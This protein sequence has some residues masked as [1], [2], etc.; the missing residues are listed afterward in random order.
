[1]QALDVAGRARAELGRWLR[2]HASRAR[3]VGSARR[4]L[5]DDAIFVKDGKYYASAGITAGI[6]LCLAFVEEDLGQE[7]ALQ[8]AREMVVYLKRSGGQLQYA[9]PLLV[10]T[11]A[12]GR[13]DDVTQWIRGHLNADLTVEAIAERINL[14]PRHRFGGASS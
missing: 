5:G 8:V 11:Q 2:N 12:K 6:D 10:Q 1:M 4:T 9:L 7:V 3:R 13:F 14:S